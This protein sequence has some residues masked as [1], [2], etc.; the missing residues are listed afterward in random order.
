[1]MTW[2]IMSRDSVS[3]T[4]L[5]ARRRNVRLEDTIF[6]DH[7]GPRVYDNASME[8]CEA[9]ST[10]AS[11]RSSEHNSTNSGTDSQTR[12]AV[13]THYYSRFYVLAISILLWVM[14]SSMTRAATRTLPQAL[15][16]RRAAPEQ[17]K[18]DRHSERKEPSFVEYATTACAT[19]IL[20]AQDFPKPYVNRA[21]RVLAINAG[22]NPFAS[23]HIVFDNDSTIHVCKHQPLATQL[24]G[25][26]ER[27]ITG[28]N[29]SDDNSLSYNQKCNFMSPLLGAVPLCPGAAVNIISQ[30]L[31]KDQGFKVD[32]Y[33][34]EDKY[35]LTHPRDTQ[36][37]FEFDRMTVQGRKL[38]HYIM[39]HKTRKSP[40]SKAPFQVV[41]GL[42]RSVP[43]ATVSENAAKYT[44]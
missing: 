14:L 26:E 27:V 16:S 10:T 24:N 8:Q 22:T 39:D 12:A 29:D 6:A 35:V 25:C 21:E 34:D 13:V 23:N 38:R 5:R 11:E 3:R 17:V 44:K 36:L 40:R 4:N 15:K 31:C 32:Y 41:M 42:T 19:R 37:R 2:Y 28:I 18:H 43:N 33:D 7:G 9:T 1:M 30:G 20:C